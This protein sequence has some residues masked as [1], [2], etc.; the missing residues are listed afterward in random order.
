M[1][2]QDECLNLEIMN[3]LENI[4]EPEQ[5][6]NG[7]KMFYKGYKT[8]Y[9]FTKFK[10]FRC[11]GNTIRNDMVAIDLINNRTNKINMKKRKRMCSK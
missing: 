2:S 5:K 7:R 10:T 9:D 3:K 4:R 6:N 11:F 1:L 8:I